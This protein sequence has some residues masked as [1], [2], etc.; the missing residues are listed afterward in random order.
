[1]TDITVFNFLTSTHLPFGREVPI[2]HLTILPVST[3]KTLP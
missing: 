3:Y 1:M 2:I